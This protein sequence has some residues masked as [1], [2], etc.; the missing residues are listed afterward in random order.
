MEDRKKTLLKVTPKLAEFSNGLVPLREAREFFSI[1][2]DT[3]LELPKD[4]PYVWSNAVVSMDGRT[5]FLEDVNSA[6]SVALAHIK[7]SGSISDWRMLNVGWCYSDAIIGTAEIIRNEPDV[8]WCPSFEDLEEER[9]RIK[10]KDNKYPIHVTLTA[11]GDLP[12]NYKIFTDNRFK[13][14]IYTTAKGRAKIRSNL[15]LHCNHKTEEQWEKQNHTVVVV[16]DESSDKVD[17]SKM[18]TH[19]KT[20]ENVNYV[21]LTAGS[22][23]FGQMLRLKLI[24]DIRITYS[25]LII[26]GLSTHNQTRPLYYDTNSDKTHTPFTEKTHP[27]IHYA[28][29]RSFGEHHLFIRASVEYRH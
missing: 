9:I 2:S 20:K 19:L 17:L 29:I 8:V 12:L 11:T 15:E 22:L 21:D 1:S 3:I 23:V 4:R 24:D 13:T 10:G 14:I 28:G 18:L 7:D 6:K 16:I 25:G 26:G 5:S 27:L